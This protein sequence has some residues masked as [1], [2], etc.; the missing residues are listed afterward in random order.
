MASELKI[1]LKKPEDFDTYWQRTMDELSSLPIAPELEVLHLRST[2]FA[3]TYGLRFTSIGPYRIFAYYTMPRGRG[4]FP[5]RYYV[6]AYSSV[7]HIPPYEDRK[8]FV[9]IALCHR[10]M[11]LSDKPFAAGFP[12]LLTVGIDDKETYVYRGIV[13]DSCRAMDY[14]LSRPEVDKSR[15]ALIGGGDLAF[16]TAALRPQ[17]KAAVCGAPMFYAAS[18][19]IPT[20]DAYPLEEINDYTRTHPERKDRAYRTISY[21]DPTFFAPRIKAKVLLQCG[22]KGALFSEENA[23]PL[24][25]ALGNRCEAR[26]S[27]GLGYTEHVFA[28]EWLKRTL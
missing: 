16:M 24:I 25:E 19:L 9:T 5:V 22:G 17:G 6:P 23:H 21:F 14:L 18:S 26:V 27:T 2:D 8:E 15:I 28:E 12:G 3:T 1:A 20:T 13:A 4:P 7:I 11:R 10:G